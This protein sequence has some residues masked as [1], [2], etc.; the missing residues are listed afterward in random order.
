MSKLTT[1]QVAAV[2]KAVM[3]CETRVESGHVRLLRIGKRGSWDVTSY[4]GWWNPDLNGGDEARLQ[5][6]A[7]VEW[8]DENGVER[9]VLSERAARYRQARKNKNTPALI[10]LCHEL[11]ENNDG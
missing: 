6:L 2:V 7:I 8:L 5:A 11:L 9:V 10:E 4:L 1:D 3:R